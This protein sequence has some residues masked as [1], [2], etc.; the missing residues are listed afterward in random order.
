MKDEPPDHQPA[1]LALVSLSV[2]IDRVLLSCHSPSAYRLGSLPS[3]QTWANRF[4]SIRGSA[5]PEAG[6]PVKVGSQCMPGQLRGRHPAQGYTA[7]IESNG[8]VNLWRVDNWTLLGSNSIPGFSLGTWYTLALRANGTQLS[9][10]VNGST[11]IGP[12]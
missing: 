4:D 5:L 3:E 11:V 12:V 1:R 8:T 9:V 7:E 6:D 10:E 2:V